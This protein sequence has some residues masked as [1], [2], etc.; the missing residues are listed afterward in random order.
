MLYL[1]N[2]GTASIVISAKDNVIY[3]NTYFTFEILNKDS[4]K[5]TLFTNTNLSSSPY[6]NMYIITVTQSGLTSGGTAGII[7]VPP[8]QYSY[9]VYEMVEQYNLDILNA[10]GVVE[11]G[12]L[13]IPGTVSVP[14][15]FRISE[16]IKVF[17][18]N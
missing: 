12:I 14:D 10:I 15:T 17:R 4:L 1:N 16:N 3:P 8:G 6:Y 13:N 5:T 18:T 9:K 7:S 2:G 11:Y